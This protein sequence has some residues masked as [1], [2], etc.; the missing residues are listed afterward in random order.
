MRLEERVL[1][2][3]GGLY[4]APIAVEDVLA[5]SDQSARAFDGALVDGVGGDAGIVRRSR[6]ARGATSVLS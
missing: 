6:R 3:S 1:V 2:F 4:V 5:T